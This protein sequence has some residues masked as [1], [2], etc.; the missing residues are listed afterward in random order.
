VTFARPTLPELVERSEAELAARLGLGA[1]LERSVLKVLART[2]AGGLHGLYGYLDFVSRQVV[3]LTADADVLE[4]WADLY[5]LE[6]R[7]AVGAGGPV[8]FSGTSGTN[9]PI[10]LVVQRAD[11]RRFAT[12][13]AGTVAA[14]TLT[15]TVS[16][17]LPGLG[18]NTAAGTTL[19]LS[20][21]LVGVASAVVATGGLVD[22]LDQETDQELRDRFRAFVSARPQGGSFADYDAW[23]REVAGV[24]R[25]FV[26]ENGLGLGTVVVLFAV[27]DDPAGP[28]PSAGKV[29]EVQTRLTD[30]TRRD[31]RPV[32]AAVTTLAPVQQLVPV[33]VQ[34]TPNTLPVQE[35]VKDSLRAMLVREARPGGTVTRGKFVEAI[36]TAAGEQDHVLSV[37]AGDVVVGATSLLLLGT[38]TFT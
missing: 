9:V 19:A 5:G 17:E 36:A 10:G 30:P 2:W 13:T 27:D 37:P 26:Q 23:A 28:I 24:T 6:R 25:V 22:G 3:P 38:V 21:P 33:T 8:T 31:A 14:G 20:T 32:C 7:A 35:A 18:S 12:T 29:V 11:G 1:L 15:L 4:R 16:A 34:L